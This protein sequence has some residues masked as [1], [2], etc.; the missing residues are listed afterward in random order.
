M[1]GLN[2]LIERHNCGLSSILADEMGLG[3]TLQVVSF[4]SYLK[5]SKVF[6]VAGE[7]RVNRART[8]RLCLHFRVLL[9]Q[10]RLW[11]LRQ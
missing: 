7:R 4:L 5:A 11:S 1:V 2:W 8:L 6:N 3:K 9:A 10:D